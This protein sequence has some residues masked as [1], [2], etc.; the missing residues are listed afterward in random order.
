MNI[1]IP[2]AK[3]VSEDLQN[4]GKLPSIIY[5]VTDKI[6][7]DFL[8]KQY[9]DKTDK[10]KIMCY[11]NAEKV[12]AKLDKFN[13]V[14]II[15][16]PKIEDLAHTI[17]YALDGEKSVIINFGDTIVMDNIYENEND[18]FYYAIDYL[19]EK[20]TYFEIENGKLV[21][22]YDKIN[23]G[24]NERQKHKLFVGV[25]YLSDAIEFKRC[26]R[27]A[28]ENS[29]DKISA[30]Y[31]ALQQYSRIH[32]LNAIETSNWFDVGHADKYYNAKLEVK[33]REFNHIKIDKNR[34]ILTKFSDD[35]DKFIGEIKWYLKLPSDVEYIRPRI[36]DYSLDYNRPYVSMEYYSYH[37]V[38]ELFINADL[39]VNQWETIFERIRYVCNDLKR[40]KVRDKNIVGSLKSMYLTKTFQRFDIIRNDKKFN[41]FFKKNISVN[42]IK[43]KSLT[44]IEKIL[45]EIIP[46]MLFDVEEFSIIHGDLC[47][48]NMMIDNNLSF[49][50]VIDPRGKFGFYDIYGDFR[51]ELAKL[52]HSLDGK[53]DYIIKDLFEIDF[54]DCNINYTILDKDRSFDLYQVFIKVFYN[55]IG[56]NMKKI[57]LIEAL[58]FLSMIPLHGENYL[59]QL[60][61]L[62]TGLEILDRVIDIKVR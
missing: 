60:V 18:C 20:W 3:L 15:D 7:F 61:M 16:I 54:N 45:K 42:G 46:C 48:A 47:F 58:L 44:D 22:I 14:Q 37:T 51:Y 26:L 12:H 43:Y 19:S 59:H 4:I 30:F 13:K 29:D 27:Y 5:P 38:H 33:A 34:G 11:E 57:E 41:A 50:K 36:F 62:A 49:I 39:N 53:Y 9:Y 28:F 55:E 32:K 24:D 6:V 31:V 17:F 1:I 40:Y 56:N 35:K 2:S 25:F 23:K 8:Y 21:N 52:L 10:F